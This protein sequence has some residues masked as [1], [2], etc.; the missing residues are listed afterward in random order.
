MN[1]VQDLTPAK[2]EWGDVPMIPIP[3]PGETPFL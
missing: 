3:V 2:L 1:S